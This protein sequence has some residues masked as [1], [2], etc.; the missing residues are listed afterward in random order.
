MFI[1]EALQRR[2]HMERQLVVIKGDALC[3]DK[4][5]KEAKRIVVQGSQPYVSLYVRYLFSSLLRFLNSRFV[6]AV[7]NLVCLTL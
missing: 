6:V 1:R 4:T 3:H 5:F 2:H 7:P